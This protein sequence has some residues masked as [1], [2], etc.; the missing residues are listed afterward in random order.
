MEEKSGQEKIYIFDS[1]YTNEHIQLLK[2]IYSRLSPQAKQSFAPIIKYLEF[3]YTISLTKS[4]FPSDI[5]QSKEENDTISMLTHI[6]EDIKPILNE[7]ERKQFSKI[8]EIYKMFMSFQQIQKT[9]EQF[10]EMTGIKLEDMLGH[11]FKQDDL[12]S[13]LM[14]GDSQNIMQSFF[15][16]AGGTNL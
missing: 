4:G 13:M 9:M 11:D 16:A 10:E 15:N 6:Y 7:N 5:N 3:R 8:D 12:L 14:K 1:L 2:I